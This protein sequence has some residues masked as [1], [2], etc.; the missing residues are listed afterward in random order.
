MNSYELNSE[1]VGTQKRLQGINRNPQ[2]YLSNKEMN[3]YDKR[4]INMASM[5]KS[6]KP[7]TFEDLEFMRQIQTGLKFAPVTNLNSERAV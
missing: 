3:L 5:A 4:L 6:A 2:K 1:A 7:L